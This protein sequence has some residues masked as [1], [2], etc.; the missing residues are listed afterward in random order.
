LSS[1]LRKLK[2]S[3]FFNR[4]ETDKDVETQTNSSNVRTKRTRSG[5]KEWVAVEVWD[6]AKIALEKVKDRWGLKFENKTE[7]VCKAYY[8]CK[9]VPQRQKTAKLDCFLSQLSF[10]FNFPKMQI[11]VLFMP[12]LP[13]SFAGIGFLYYYYAAQP[14]KTENSIHS[15]FKSAGTSARVTSSLCSLQ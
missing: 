4:N 2:S 11:M 3:L 8:R 13:T 5:N 7:D 14:M 1:R 12:T 9:K 6:N 15:A 10:L